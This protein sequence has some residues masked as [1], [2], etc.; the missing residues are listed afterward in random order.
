MSDQMTDTTAESTGGC[1]GCACGDG[2]CGGQGAAPVVDLGTVPSEVRRSVVE[3]VIAAVPVDS[4]VILVA[5]HEVLPL[6][7]ALD[8]SDS[9]AL[10]ATYEEEGPELWALRVRRIR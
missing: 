9:G 8:E 3:A 7:R 1:A 2:G 4:D 10:Q 6:L 5:P